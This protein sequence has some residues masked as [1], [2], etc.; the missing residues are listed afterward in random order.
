MSMTRDA[1]DTMASL[2]YLERLDAVREIQLERGIQGEILP[3]DFFI[4]GERAA[5]Q[6]TKK[7]YFTRIQRDIFLKPE[8]A[9]ELTD[10]QDFDARSTK[11]VEMA[12]LESHRTIV[13]IPWVG[14]PEYG[15]LGDM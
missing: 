9:S 14:H 4:R 13:K 1:R 12:M 10:D 15:D 6:E 7:E 5:L 3:E 2:F 8:K 11:L